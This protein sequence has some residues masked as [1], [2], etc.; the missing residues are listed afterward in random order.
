MIVDLMQRK[1]LLIKKKEG[2]FLWVVFV[3]VSLA[4]YSL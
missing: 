1:K 4:F 3:L 2:E